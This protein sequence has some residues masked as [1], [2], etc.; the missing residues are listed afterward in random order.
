MIYKSTT[1]MIYAFFK[2]SD[3][4]CDSYYVKDVLMMTNIC[5]AALVIFG[6]ANQISSDLNQCSQ[7]VP[8]E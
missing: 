3:Q 8:I 2:T 7:N 4:T 1:M 5:K 6:D